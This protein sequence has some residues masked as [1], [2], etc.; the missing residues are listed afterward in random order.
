MLKKTQMK[1]KRLIRLKKTWRRLKDL[2][3]TLTKRSSNFAN[4]ISKDVTLGP[5]SMRT[6]RK[7]KRK[8]KRQ[9]PS[10]KNLKVQRKIQSS[11]K[12]LEVQSQNLL[13]TKSRRKYHLTKRS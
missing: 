2:L 10:L 3:K 7:P 8:K 6:K 9:R 1:K 12:A 13:M 11:N 4:M 5:R